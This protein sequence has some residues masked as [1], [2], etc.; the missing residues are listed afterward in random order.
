MRFGRCL[1]V[2]GCGIVRVRQDH[3]DNNELAEV[4]DLHQ[5]AKRW[6]FFKDI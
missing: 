5:D 3:F 1:P 2:A 4:A 6:L